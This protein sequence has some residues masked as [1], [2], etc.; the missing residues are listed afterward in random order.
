MHLLPLGGDFGGKGSFMDIPLTYFLARA[1]GRPLRLAM[2]YSQELMAGNPRHSATIRVR[3]DVSNDG[4]IV[5]RWV[6]RYFA[7]RGYPACKTSPDT[8]P[9][10]FPRG[11]SGPS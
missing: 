5:A 2:T 6:R 9:P 11:A 4:R 7:S 8:T 10:G 1:A 3:S